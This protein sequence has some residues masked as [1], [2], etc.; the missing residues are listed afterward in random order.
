MN[1]VRCNITKRQQDEAAL[2]GARVRQDE[3]AVAQGAVAVDQ[4]K[5][6]DTGGVG[7]AADTSRSGFDGMEVVKQPFGRAIPFKTGHA[8][9]EIRLGGGRDGGG[10][11]PG[12][13]GGDAQAWEAPQG[14]HTGAAGHQR[15]RP[16][17]VWQV[18]ANRN[19]DHRR[20]T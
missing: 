1:P 19:Q 12:R 7:D 5:I 10:A 9:A 14:L 11:I 13:D 16:G 20:V 2:V 8:V 18:G 3:R 6:K 17:A 15:Q 4:V